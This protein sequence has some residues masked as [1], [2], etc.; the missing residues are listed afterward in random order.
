MSDKRVDPSAENS[1]ALV[2]AVK[3]NH[4]EI[5]KLLLS[6]R[7][8]DLMI[9]SNAT[10][11]WASRNGHVDIVQLLMNDSRMNPS[12]VSTAGKEYLSTTTIQHSLSSP[13]KNIALCGAIRNG[14]MNIVK[15]LMSVERVD[16]SAS[17]NYVIRMAS[18]EGDCDMVKLLL[19]R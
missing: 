6:D 2:S 15:L 9:N 8:V 17:N 14:H 10:L 11:N 5:I 19:G 1:A 12:A 3:K 13:F 7:R 16:P 4:V 18:I